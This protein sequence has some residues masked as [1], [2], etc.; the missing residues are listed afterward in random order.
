MN[1]NFY[2]LKERFEEYYNLTIEAESNVKAKPRT[3]AIS[4]TKLDNSTKD[5]QLETFEY[6]WNDDFENR[7]I[8]SIKGKIVSIDN[9][10]VEKKKIDTNTHCEGSNSGIYSAF[11]SCTCILIEICWF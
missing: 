10:I 7:Q 5:S 9:S 6:W 2:F 8:Q 4:F 3:S 1:S 11:Y